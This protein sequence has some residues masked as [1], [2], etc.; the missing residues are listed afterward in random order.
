MDDY[1]AAGPLIAA[2]LRE[3]LPDANLFE[4]R[5]KPALHE[6][7]TLAPAIILLLEDDLPDDGNGRFAVT[8]ITQTWVC[9]VATRDE[10]RSAGII[11]ARVMSA[12]SGWRLP[13]G[14]FL[15]LRRVRS[16]YPIENSPGGINYFPV[17]FQT[18]FVFTSSINDNKR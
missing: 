14:V 1:L 12:L 13:G 4:S 6:T 18:E 16:A 11:I 5:G 10:D 8:K 3:M 9:L 2:R 17:A 7:P 15:P